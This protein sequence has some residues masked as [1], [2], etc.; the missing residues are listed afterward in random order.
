MHDVI[1]LGNMIE[2]KGGIYDLFSTLLS[3]AAI[4]VLVLGVLIAIIHSAAKNTTISLTN[5]NLVIK[6]SFWSKKI[7]LENILIDE[8]K[9][10]NLSENSDYQLSFRTSGVNLANVKMGWMRLKNKSKALVFI[11][12]KKNVA[13]I[14]TKDFQILFSMNNIDEFI[15]K[16]KAAR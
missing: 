9:P 5:E 7:P 3:V 11:T 13:L 1:F 14:P 12:D 2:P 10:I 8:I 16:I 15:S 4:V 6:S